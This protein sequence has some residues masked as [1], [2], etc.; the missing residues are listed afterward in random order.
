MANATVTVLEADGLTETD[1]VVLDVGRQAAA[2]SKSV[3]LA[4]ED[5]AVLDGILTDTELR[6]TP[7]PV[8]GTV[9]ANLSATDNT[10]LDN[11]DT[12]TSR[13][14]SS[15]TNIAPGGALATTSFVTGGRYDSTQK[16]LTDGQE[17]SWAMSARGA[18]I[19]GYGVE[20]AIPGTGATNLGKA[21]DSAAGAT[22]TGVTT[23]V[24]RDDALS[25]LTPVDGDYTTLRVGSTGKLWSHDESAI[26]AIE[27]LRD[28]A[29][30]DTVQTAIEN[31]GIADIA[32][33][34]AASAV[35]PALMGGYASAAAPSD[36]SA[37]T[38]AV[39][40]WHLR[41]GAYA[42]NI[43]AA[44]ALIPGDATNG[45][46]VDVTRLSAV[47]HDA[48]T[49]ENP[50]KVGAH[51]IAGLSGATLVAAADKTYLYA[52]LDG[53]QIVRP[54]CGLEDIVSGVA[55]ITDGSSTSVIASAG[56]GVKNYITTAI[57]ANSSATAVT[58]DLRDG[59]AG[60]VKA[61][62]PVPAN[63][64]GA[65]CN[66]P[67]PLPFSAATAVCADPSAAA[68]TVTVTLVGFKSK[69]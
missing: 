57:F 55:A 13:L 40:A 51:A 36:V 62:F 43:T 15:A 42:V 11:I 14:T 33:D 19:V 10:V 12:A 56:A 59:A 20:G 54:H 28:T 29:T 24:V 63:V 4:T 47:A 2:A 22:D 9:T 26:S 30:L 17:A 64:S 45:L 1:V 5:K 7:V 31:G 58:V 39:R 6:A 50:V 16:T 68:S 48:A 37:D 60:S 52:G 32:H 23:L 41:N 34:A 66:L 8:S 46:D 69:V 18:K 21:V 49:A 65:V 61:T 38:D 53:A 25:T 3:T 35:N 44:G 67:V 27:A